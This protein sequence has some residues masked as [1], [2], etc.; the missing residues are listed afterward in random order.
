MPELPWRDFIEGP[1]HSAAQAPWRHDPAYAVL[2]EEAGL[3]DSIG[4]HVASA[5][6]QVLGLVQ[7]LTQVDLK[8][9][10]HATRPAWGLSLGFGMNVL[11]PHDLLQI[12]E[13]DGVHAY[14]WID[15][16]VIEAAQT[17]QSLRAEAPDLPSRLRLYHGTIGD[18]SALADGSVRVVHVANVF[19]WEI[20]M[21]PETFDAAVR[22]LL[23]VLG[24]GGIVFSR[25]SA[26]VLEESL[27]PH[28]Q[29][30][31]HTPQVTVFQKE[32]ACTEGCAAGSATDEPD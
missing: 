8:A 12:L 1:L 29:W 23:R 17:L 25:G 9:V 21:M 19:N 7:A 31:L 26:G 5:L 32:S 15:E 22:E 14:E 18:L 3:R 10:I 27:A 24:D 20:P 2:A 11:E 30:L 16:Q 6:T 28:G 4:G 13:L